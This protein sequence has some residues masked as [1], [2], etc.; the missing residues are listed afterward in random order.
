MEQYTISLIVNDHAGV[1]SRIAGLFTRRGYNIDSLSVG[2]TE[3]PGIARMTIT[4]SIEDGTSEQVKK[5]CYKLVDVIKVMDMTPEDSV[6][7]E[8]ILVKVALNDVNRQR[9]IDAVKIYKGH[10]VSYAKDSAIIE[11]TGDKQKVEAFLNLLESEGVKELIRTG[12]TA[13]KR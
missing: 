6:F 8:L 3:E 7:R 5:Q 1:L 2:K 13:L 9:I 4:Y 10:I 12:F 11:L